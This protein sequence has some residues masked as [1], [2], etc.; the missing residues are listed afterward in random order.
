MLYY[1]W[2]ESDG[3]S[4]CWS[5]IHASTHSKW[6][7]RNVAE[8]VV[9]LIQ[10]NCFINLYFTQNETYNYLFGIGGL[11]GGFDGSGMALGVC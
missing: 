8:N 7:S 3:A 5:I 1:H 9:V 2:P 11:V 6:R 4:V 10:S